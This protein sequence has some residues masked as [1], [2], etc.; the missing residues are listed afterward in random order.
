MALGYGGNPYGPAGT[1][2]AGGVGVGRA[3]WGMLGQM[4]MINPKNAAKIYGGGAS[5]LFLEAE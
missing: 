4:V 2:G 1:G 5:L 3:S